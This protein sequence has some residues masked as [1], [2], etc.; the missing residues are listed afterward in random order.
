MRIEKLALLAV[1]LRA[2]AVVVGGVNGQA[3]FALRA[4][5][6]DIIAKRR[7]AAAV[8]TRQLPVHKHAGFIVDRAEMQQHSPGQLL[9]RHGERAQIPHSGDKILISDAAQIAFRAERDGD[10]PVERFAL[11]KPAVQSA[12]AKIK[13]KLP[14]AI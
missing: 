1:R 3:V 13:G 8:R 10:R 6:R 14:F 2:V 9:L 11:L 12:H 7:V 5:L 4:Q